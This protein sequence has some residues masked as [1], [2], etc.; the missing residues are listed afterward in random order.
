MNTHLRYFCRVSNLKLVAIS[1][2]I[3]FALI[4][5]FAVVNAS[6]SKAMAEDSNAVDVTA[7]DITINNPTSTGGASAS[8]DRSVYVVDDE[9][10]VNW[11][12]GTSGSDF[13]LPTS[14]KYG[15]ITKNATELI[16]V[17]QMQEQNSE[18]LR[19]MSSDGNMTTYDSLS[20]Y[21]SQ[22]HSVSLGKV[23][24]LNTT[25][26]ITWQVVTP[27]YR[28][29]N[30]ITSEHL[31]TT[32]KTEYDNFVS[33]G[34]TN[35]DYWIGEGISW[36]APTTGTKVERYYNAGL[37]AQGHSSHYYSSDATEIANLKAAGWTYDAGCDL[38]SGGTTPIYTCYNEALG[39][40]HHYTSSKTEWQNLS[41]NGWQLEEDKNGVNP[42]KSPEGVF[43]G[44][45][46]TS[47]NYSGNYYKVNHVLEGATSAF[48]TQ[49]VSGVAGQTTAA[50]ALS[51]PGYV[52]T[53]NTETISSNNST[54]VSVNYTK[55][56]YQIKLNYNLE[57]EQA[58][59]VDVK[60]AAAMNPETP[61]ANGKVFKGWFYDSK[62]TKPFVAGSAMPASDVRL[63]AQWEDEN[64]G[65]GGT[66]GE[67]GG[68]QP[69]EKTFTVTFKYN[70]GLVKVTSGDVQTVAEGKTVSAPT[71][72]LLN[73]ETL[74]KT[75]YYEADAT[76]SV[77]NPSAI[78]LTTYTI[79]K[80]TYIYI[81]PQYKQ[82]QQETSGGPLNFDNFKVDT[83]NKVYN[84]AHI[85][86]SV[87]SD[88]YTTDA[89]D[90]TYGDNRNA[91]KGTI[92]V[93]GKG[94]Y[95]GTKEY[96]FNITTRAVTVTGIVAGKKYADGT[97]NANLN[98]SSM[99][100]S[101]KVAGDDLWATATGTY[102]SSEVGYGYII[103]ISNITLT[104]NSASNYYVNTQ[105]SQKSAFGDIVTGY[106]TIVYHS[107]DGSAIEKTTTETRT[108]GDLKSLAE[109]PF[110]KEG[111]GFKYWTTNA[112]GTG[113]VFGDGYT[114]D[115]VTTIEGQ[116]VDLYAQW[117]TTALGDFWIAKSSK[118]TTSLDN[119]GVA[120]PEYT[121]PTA[122]VLYTQTDLAEIFP[123]LKSQVNS[124]VRASD[125]EILDSGETNYVRLFSQW[126]DN[127]NYHLY[128][129]INGT[130]GTSEND[131]VE[132]RVVQVGSHDN[133][134][135]VVTWQAT[136]V[137]PEQWGIWITA[138]SDAAR[139]YNNW[140]TTD[141]HFAMAKEDGVVSK[142][143]KASLRTWGNTITPEKTYVNGNNTVTGG[144]GSSW[145]W[146]MS[147]SEMSKIDKDDWSILKNEGSQYD[148][149]ADKGLT[150]TSSSKAI[151]ELGKK[152]DGT[153]TESP[154]A[155]R[156]FS[157]QTNC[158]WL[159]TAWRGTHWQGKEQ[160]YY[161]ASTNSH[162]FDGKSY[163]N[164]S[165]NGYDAR[166]I[167]PCLA[168]G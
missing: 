17:D 64:T 111:C 144:A 68:D 21:A 76:G 65:G 91:G 102:E 2:T 134:D 94:S 110:V 32:Q 26:E 148:F 130:D 42:A 69:A 146:I 83:S 51:V 92:T 34:R 147:A 113:S 16:S 107:N 161:Y 124:R 86:P 123:K 67:T 159:R 77:T 72:E 158:V 98:Y 20:A 10:I 43:Q 160:D 122:N 162:W 61:S 152:R 85:T 18:Y 30:M 145:L 55:A 131:Y 99:Q 165:A 150:Y 164:G 4:G 116:T 129:Q 78:D 114:G 28:L 31:F 133:D 45:V 155:K 12:G 57:G 47:W 168:W 36:L 38:I 56:N 128:T 109:V 14:I 153:G 82:T 29:Y 88:V 89:Y 106:Y 27:V 11:K 53:A 117:T 81:S 3:I 60:Y 80:D 132:F 70:A 93:T 126:M 79:T 84:G 154:E 101:G 33:V 74:A 118:I 40:A 90:V 136:H 121:S 9:L 120:N 22:T 157:S 142:L 8:L 119:A 7:V 135:S 138:G 151:D 44:V 112:D 1:A 141:L 66:G 48:A 23:S 15:N 49:W 37:G 96:S 105:G 115:V 95:T 163:M 58:K 25:V 6:S 62:F 13:V 125:P 73:G 100:I 104:G 52:G 5:A 97:R 63:F 54:V 41:A 103:T 143:F 87:S 108:Y 137:L 71:I 59:T 19:R 149:W 75:D 35:Q 139:N 156:I 24:A 46:A 39:S 167:V 50:Q 166:G 127:D 140:N